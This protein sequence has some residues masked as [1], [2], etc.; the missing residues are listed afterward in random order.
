ML[1]FLSKGLF[2]AVVAL[3]RL[4]PLRAK[5]RCIIRTP[6]SEE[7]PRPTELNG[8]PS[9]RTDGCG[10][11]LMEITLNK[12]SLKIPSQDT[13][14]KR[15]ATLAVSFTYPCSANYKVAKITEPLGLA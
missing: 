11:A 5:E 12:T 13:T 15:E 8:L 6:G 4:C 2:S 9:W 7:Q 14:K 3:V 10:K 1:T